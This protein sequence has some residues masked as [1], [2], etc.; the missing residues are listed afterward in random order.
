MNL[1][2]VVNLY[3][4]AK[5]SGERLIEII[6]AK[7]DIVEKENAIDKPIKGDVLF[8]NVSLN[9]TEDNDEALKNINFHAWAGKTIGLI[10]TTGLG[11]TR[12]TQII[13]RFY[14]SID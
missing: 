6:D 1:G 10:S 11:K 12:I 8:D 2:F 14:D 5:A 3:S 13:A 4:Q 9:Y 7:E